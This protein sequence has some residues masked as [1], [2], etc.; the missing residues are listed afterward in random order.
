LMNGDLVRVRHQIQNPSARIL[1]D[2][3]IIRSGFPDSALG[4]SIICE[5]KDL[6]SFLVVFDLKAEKQSVRY[7]VILPGPTNPGLTVYERIAELKKTKKPIQHR[8]RLIPQ[9]NYLKDPKLAFASHYYWE[10]ICT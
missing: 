7:G 10:T 5:P 6:Q 4:I 3:G 8:I 2:W 1:P 9:D